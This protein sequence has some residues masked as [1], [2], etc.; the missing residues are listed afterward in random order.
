[1]L[2]VSLYL[3]VY[4]TLA[5]FVAT[6]S[7]RDIGHRNSITEEG[8][9]SFHDAIHARDHKE[10]DQDIHDDVDHRDLQQRNQLSFH[11]SMSFGDLQY[12]SQAFLDMQAMVQY[13][14]QN[15]NIAV[16]DRYFDPV[17]GRNV[18]KIFQAVQSLSSVGG[19]PRPAG[20]ANADGPYDL[21]DIT[22]RRTNKPYAFLAHSQGINFAAA[23]RDGRAPTITVTNAGWNA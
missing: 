7:P 22:V 23:G 20:V 11:S 12:L 17:D 4:L 1:M 2:K 13:V 19:H 15:P 6:I 9:E 10:A 18:T 8:Y 16:L 21:Q 3:R 14:A 5:I